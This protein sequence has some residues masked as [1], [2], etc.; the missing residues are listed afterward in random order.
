MSLALFAM[1][2]A[3]AAPQAAP[4]IPAARA[5]HEPAPELA[6]QPLA[7]GRTEQALLTL[8]K[9]SAAN[10]HDAGV[11]INLG[12]AYARIGEDARARA[13]FERAAACHE[14]IELQTADGSATDSRRL[15]RAALK[16]LARGEFRD[17]AQPASHLT[18]SGR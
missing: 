2:I 15:A 10:P 16:M 9:A 12:I 18:Y 13:A 8:E 4:Q 11:L 17:T 7:A 14:V 6:V 3:V 5:A 1:A